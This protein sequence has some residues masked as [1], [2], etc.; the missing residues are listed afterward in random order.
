VATKIARQGRNDNDGSLASRLRGFA[1]STIAQTERERPIVRILAALARAARDHGAGA[2]KLLGDM[3]RVAKAYLGPD[4]DPYL[5]DSPKRAPERA[6]N[7]LAE[8]LEMVI[9]LGPGVRR[10]LEFE[11]MKREE[12]ARAHGAH[13]RRSGLQQ[14]ALEQPEG[15][16]EPNATPRQLARVF[17]NAL[18]SERM[19]AL[20]RRIEKP[21]EA[22]SAEIEERFREIFNTNSVVEGARVARAGLGALGYPNA[23][24]L[25]Y[26]SR[27][28]RR[29]PGPL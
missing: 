3:D 11:K 23:R 19:S 26:D 27:V 29:P 17:V 7:E 15:R 10:S 1:L 5:D 24:K 9:V 6:F 25:G 13:P 20:A 8:L 28:K 14:K 22:T 21:L 16:R 2:D 4:D 12:R 18:G